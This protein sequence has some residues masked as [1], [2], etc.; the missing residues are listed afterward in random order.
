MAQIMA[1][2]TKIV[3]YRSISVI[4]DDDFLQLLYLDLNQQQAN[5]AIGLLIS[6]ELPLLIQSV[7]E[8]V[9]ALLMIAI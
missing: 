6:L 4:R 8:G 5:C 3:Q 9:I 1:I 2:F 7:N